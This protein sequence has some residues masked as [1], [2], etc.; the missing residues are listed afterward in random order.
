M[1]DEPDYEVIA[2]HEEEWSRVELRQYPDVLAMVY[3][4]QRFGGGWYVRES[5]ELPINE[6]LVERLR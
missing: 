6:P 1:S 2:S 5:I 4:R 3:M